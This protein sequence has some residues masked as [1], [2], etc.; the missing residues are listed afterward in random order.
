LA[1]PVQPAV[2][3]A[4]EA[5][6]ESSPGGAAESPAAQDDVTADGD[7]GGQPKGLPTAASGAQQQVVK[8]TRL[9]HFRFRIAPIDAVGIEA[10]KVLY[11]SYG[12]TSGLFISKIL[13]TSVFQRAQP[14]IKER[15][16][17]TSVEGTPIDEFGMGRIGSFLHDPVPFESLMMMKVKPGDSV[18]VKTCGS[19]DGEKDVTHTLSMEWDDEKYNVGIR[20]IIE[21]FWERKA[22][23]YETFSGITVMALSVNHIIKL[24]RMGQPPTLGRWLLPENQQKP[25]LLITHIQR[26]NY[27]SRVLA[28]G[29][30]VSKVN[31]QEIGTLDDYRNVFE[32]AEGKKA[33]TLETDRGVFFA[34][35]FAEGLV[36]Q[37]ERAQMGMTF[38]FCES[39]VKAATKMFGKKDGAAIAPSGAVMTGASQS[40]Q[41]ETTSNGTMPTVN[42]AERVARLSMREALGMSAGLDAEEEPRRRSRVAQSGFRVLG[43]SE[44]MPE[45]ELASSLVSSNATG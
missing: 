31:D 29:M 43:T 5:P 7:A 18:T 16:F 13:Q 27:A 23:E 8:N 25:H 38:L 9:P 15:T 2:T 45:Q 21:P 14:P 11:E 20:N 34:T 22:L 35:D 37:L 33:W 40:S 4:A 24:L 28:P 42:T 12:C 30:V 6:A 3:E 41:L 19:D 36:N 32:P 26:G 17:L 10:N 44:Y 39:V 1:A